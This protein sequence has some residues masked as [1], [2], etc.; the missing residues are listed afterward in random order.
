MAQSAIP[1]IW[2]VEIGIIMV[3]SQTGPKVS[4]N[5]YQRISQ[6]LWNTPVI[7]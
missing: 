4:E 1:V 7:L 2:H 5:L 3:K 6:S